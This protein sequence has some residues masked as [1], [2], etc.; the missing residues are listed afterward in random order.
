M[1]Q[2][3]SKSEPRKFTASEIALLT[4]MMREARRWSQETLAEATGLN[5]RTVQRVERGEFTDEE[6]RRALLRAFGSP[7]LEFFSQEHRFP[8]EDEV[9]TA[10]TQ[11]EQE[12]LLLPVAVATSARELGR[13]YETCTMDVSDPATNLT[14][15]AARAY[16]ALTDYLRDFRDIAAEIAEVEKMAYYAELQSLLEQLN[17]AKI[18]VCYATR[19]VK[20][21]NPDWKDPSPWP[22]E[23]VYL[24]AF[25]Q[26]KVPA[27]MAVQR[28]VQL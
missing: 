4:K 22:V 19:K 15:D 27:K 25:H 13:L 7:N 17:A 11:F 23:F 3:E 16:A 10:E 26:G 28:T 12:H 8:T 9:K 5:V 24:S 1:I 21:I 20:L 6:T 14:E 2:V 18:D